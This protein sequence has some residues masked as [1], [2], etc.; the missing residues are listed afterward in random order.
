[1][2][3]VFRK[4]AVLYGLKQAPRLWFQDIKNHL[5]RG[6]YTQGRWEPTCFTKTQNGQRT[7]VLIY[8]DDIIITGPNNSHIE[9][10]RK[11]IESK[12][13]IGSYEDIESYLGMFVSTSSTGFRYSMESKINNLIDEFPTEVTMLP[14]SRVIPVIVNHG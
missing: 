13:K 6:G 9:E 11:W 4:V 14:N 8:V 7:Y 10:V 3:R 12:Y 1:M 2:P 5:V